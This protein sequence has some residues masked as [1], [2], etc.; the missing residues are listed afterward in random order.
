MGSTPP[1]ALI[2]GSGLQ[3]SEKGPSRPT[4]TGWTSPPFYS[5]LALGISYFVL[6]QSFKVSIWEFKYS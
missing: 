4:P 1:P 3:P 2:L 5:H 6:P